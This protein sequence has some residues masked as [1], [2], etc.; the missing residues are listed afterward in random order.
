LFIK[1]F[2]LYKA[3]GCSCTQQKKNM[4]LY[5]TFT[6]CVC[7]IYVITVQQ[8]Y[9]VCVQH[10]CYC[11]TNLLRV[12]VQNIHV[13][14]QQI[15]WVCVYKIY[16]TVQQIYW[17]CVYKIYVT[18]QQIYWECVYKLNVTVQQIY[19]ECVYKIYMLLY[20]RSTESVCTN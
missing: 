10:I 13:T 19:W 5:K 18:V 6:G 17:E 15:Y 11:T 2:I 12:C 9:W 8:I 4:L 20:S 14:V 3:P 16:V 1:G 7:N